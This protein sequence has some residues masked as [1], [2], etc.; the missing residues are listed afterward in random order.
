MRYPA[1]TNVAVTRRTE[2]ARAETLVRGARS[3]AAGMVEASLIRIVVGIEPRSYRE[4]IATTVQDVRP[5]AEVVAVE[6]VALEQMV[7]C[8]LPHL[9]VC[10]R[11]SEVVETRP[12]AWILLYPDGAS[13]AVVSLAGQKATVP[14][15]DFAGLLEVVD[16]TE[17]LARERS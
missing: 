16:H 17:L 14:D 8:H 9:V 5:H 15:L 1:F 6:P 12:L 2:A 11:L 10:S 3:P 7:A 13:V 4:A